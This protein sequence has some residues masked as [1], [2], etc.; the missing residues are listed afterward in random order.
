MLLRKLLFL[1][2]LHMFLL[3]SCEG[4]LSFDEYVK[5]AEEY[6]NQGKNEKAID[7]YNKA[8]RIKPQDSST[9][10]ALG[11]LYFKEELA[12]NIAPI[13][14]NESEKLEKRRKMLSDLTISEFKKVLE[15]DP[16]KW[17]ARYIVATDHYNNKRYSEAINEYIITIKYNPKYATAY[18]ML[19]S[20]YSAIGRYDLAINN[21]N[22]A[23][24]LD[25]DTEYYY[26]HLGKVYYKMDNSNKVFEMQTKLK[27]INSKYYNDLV[28]YKYS[29]KKDN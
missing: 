9:H 19:A 27:D 11:C 17:F 2:L 14:R 5:K 23:Y 25:S 15:L 16:A 18:S 8:L 26:Y 20:S 24:R 22:E 28:D 12:L 29:N 10:Y 21:I 1:S 6:S 3:T 7:A 4:N 13:N